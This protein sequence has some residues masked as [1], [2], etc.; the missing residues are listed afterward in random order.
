MRCQEAIALL[1]H[2][3]DE[4]EKMPPALQ[5]H[6]EECDACRAK[7]DTLNNLEQQLF[8]L[9]VEAPT[10]IENR[11]KAALAQEH[12]R[13]YRPKLIASIAASALACAGVINW[14]LPLGAYEERAWE[15]LQGWLPETDWLGTEFN[16]RDQLEQAWD[17]RAAQG[18]VDSTTVVLDKMKSGELQPEDIAPMVAYLGS[19][20]AKMI[21]GC[22]FHIMGREIRLYGEMMPERVIF[23]RGERWT[24]EELQK[25]A[26]G[27]VTYGL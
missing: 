12:A 17:A 3:F 16:Y 4:A 19:D 24:V 21:N 8:R 9:P 18:V 6:L 1:E 20:A 5:A 23:S 2:C 22:V 11:V 25:S 15:F 14:L 26:P 27:L 10:G 7:A 13:Q